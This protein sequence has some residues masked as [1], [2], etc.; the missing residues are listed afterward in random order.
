MKKSSNK[1]SFANTNTSKYSKIKNGVSAPSWHHHQVEMLIYDNLFGYFWQLSDSYLHFNL[2]MVSW[3]SRNVI[4]LS[5]TF[6]CK[7]NFA[8][9]SNSVRVWGSS[10]SEWSPGQPNR[11]PLRVGRDE[12]KCNLLF[13]LLLQVRQRTEMSDNI[14]DKIHAIWWIPNKSGKFDDEVQGEERDHKQSC[15]EQK[16]SKI[17]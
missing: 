15:S 17:N 16:M 5:L 11:W 9:D 10:I 8:L 14:P 3:R 12:M 7:E 13:L 6:A 2:I 4:Y 1:W